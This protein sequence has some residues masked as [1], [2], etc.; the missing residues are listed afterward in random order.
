M[1]PFLIPDDGIPEEEIFTLIIKI[2]IEANLMDMEPSDYLSVVYV[3]TTVLLVF[4][5]KY[6]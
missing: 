3:A 4:T 5:L 2:C 1:T 6:L